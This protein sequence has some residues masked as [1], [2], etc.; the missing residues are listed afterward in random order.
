MCKGAKLQ[1]LLPIAHFTPDP[2]LAQ[3]VEKVSSRNWVPGVKKVGDHCS[4]QLKC[5]CNNIF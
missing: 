4:K 3:S 5:I 1:M 2:P